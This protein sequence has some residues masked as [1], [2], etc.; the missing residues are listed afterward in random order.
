MTKYA[1]DLEVAVT[2]VRLACRLCTTVQSRLL[3]KETQSKSDESPVTVADYGSQALI[4]W[5]LERALPKGTF[6]MVAEEDSDDLQ[7]ESAGPMLARITELVNETIKADGSITDAEP[8]SQEEIVIAIDR[9]RS[10]GGPEGRHW[11]LDPIDGTKGFVRGDQYAVALGLLDGG[12]VVLGVLGCPNLPLASMDVEA[13]RKKGEP[14][15]SLFAAYK[16]AGT[17]VEPI[18][19]SSPPTKVRVSSVEDPAWASFCESFEKKHSD[20]ELTGGIAQ[21]LGVT[22]PPCRIDSQ[23]KYG[24]MARGDAAI[25][26]RFPHAGYREKIWDH[27]AGCCV[28]E[29]AGGVVR[30]AGGNKL[31]FSKGRFLDLDRGII[32]TNARLMPVVLA[33]VQTVVK[34]QQPHGTPAKAHA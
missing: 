31:D 29:E 11:V 8:L 26:L 24:A 19:G 5:A 23:A 21:V 17:T 6:S 27:V 9:G 3:A 15:G 33:A 1:K 32:A 12:E 10:P 28:I 25:Y 13:A 34:G 4:S 18:D 14:V 20:Q 16:G 2:A 7:A 30:D 22:A